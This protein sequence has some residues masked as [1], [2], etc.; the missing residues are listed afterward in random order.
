MVHASVL[1][2]CRWSEGRARWWRWCTLRGSIVAVV[3]RV[4]LGGGDGA[5]SG[6]LSSLLERESTSAVEMV[7]ALGL[8]RR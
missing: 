2:R 3:A 4:E 1:D 6:A 5:R 7:H 8:D